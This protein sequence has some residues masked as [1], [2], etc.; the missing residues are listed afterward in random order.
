MEL[1]LFECSFEA[2]T[3]LEVLHALAFEHSVCPAAFI[4]FLV[5]LSVQDTVARLHSILEESFVATTIAPPEDASTVSFTPFELSFVDIGVF[6]RP[7]VKSSTLLFICLELPK[8]V[9]ATIEIQLTAT[10][11]MTIMEVPVN[12]FLT[13]FIKSNSISLRSL[14]FCLSNVDHIDILDKIRFIEE[15]ICVEYQRR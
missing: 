9:I 4:L 1:V 10:F 2:L 15:G 7:F 6:P 5:V 11:D 12:Y 3:V 8:I 13:A 14:T